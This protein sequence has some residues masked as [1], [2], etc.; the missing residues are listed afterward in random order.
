MFSRFRSWMTDLAITETIMRQ[1]ALLFQWMLLGIII[2]SVL[3][4]PIG[5]LLASTTAG[6]LAIAVATGALIPAAAAAWFLLRRGRFQISVLLMT[7]SWELCLAVYLIVLGLSTS[8]PILLI[9]ALPVTLAGLLTRR[10]GLLIALGSELLL[11]LIIGLLEAL[12][13]PLVGFAPPRSTSALLV[14]AVFV[15][16]IGLLG[17]F[18]FIFT[19]AL[20]TAL[21]TSQER[22]RELERVR[23]DQARVIDTQ[24]ADLRKTLETVERQKEELAQTIQSMANQQAVIQALSAPILPVLPGVLVVPLIGTLSEERAAIVQELVL[25]A[26]ERQR[27]RKVIFDVT[28][29]AVMDDEVAGSLMR[30]AA[31]L[32]LLGAAV[33]VVGVRPEVAQTLVSLSLSFE[34]VVTYANLQEAVQQLAG[35]QG[36]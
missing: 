16:G 13:Y 30:S 24:T 27:I 5:S 33:V 21:A 1:Q 34:G 8:G 36:A 25:R 20:R 4:V 29:I 15:L 28:G 22:E 12:D 35:G 32:R 26:A 18:L 11:V 17:A 14:L 23:H 7:L 9:F 10:R 31:A 19:G 6:Q 3:A 2:A